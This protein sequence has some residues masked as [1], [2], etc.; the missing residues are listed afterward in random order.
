MYNL[1]IQVSGSGEC[2]ELGTVASLEA[3]VEVAN[4][5]D[6]RLEEWF[7]KDMPP[8]KQDESI[9]AYWEGCDFF[10]TDKASGE[11]YVLEGDSISDLVKL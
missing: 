6:H 9:L 8:L 5:W 7:E 1:S 3:A 4:K 10:I 2:H 11:M